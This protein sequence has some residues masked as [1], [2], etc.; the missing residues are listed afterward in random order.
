[1]QGN[2]KHKAH[3][4]K[5]GKHR[6]SK[7]IHVLKL[8][9]KVN[10]QKP[11][12]NKWV[13]GVACWEHP[14]FN[15]GKQECPSIRN[16]IGIIHFYSVKKSPKHKMVY[17]R[18]LIFCLFFQVLAAPVKAVSYN[19]KTSS[20]IDRPSVQVLGSYKNSWYVIGFDKPGTLNKPP[21][22]RFLKYEEGFPGAKVSAIY[23]SFGDKTLYLGAAILNKRISLFYAR[24]EKWA[25]KDFLLD[26]REGRR[27][28]PIV[29]Q[30][31]YDP[32]SLTQM[33]D[34]KVIFD[35]ADEHFAV[36]G[37][38]IATSS[39]GRKTAILLKCWYRADK[40]KVIL[41]DNQTGEVYASVFDFKVLKDYLQFDELAVNN[42]GRVL[43]S[44]H[45]RSDVINFAQDSKNKGQTRYYFF[46][47][48]KGG[49]ELKSLTLTSPAGKGQFFNNPQIA[50]LNDG[51]IVV[52][53]CIYP[54]D[55][56][57][58]VKAIEVDKYDV[59]L[60]LTA[61]KEIAPDAKFLEQAGQGVRKES[62]YADVD[63]IQVLPLE[64][65]NFMMFAEYAHTTLNADK[66]QPPLHERGY[67]LTWRFGN[68][69]DVKD[70]RFIAKKQ[71]SATAAYAFSARAYRQGNDV[72]LFHNDDWESDDD[73]ETNLFCTRFPAMGA[74]PDTRKVV[75]TSE[76]FYASMENLFPSPDGKVLFTEEKLVDYDNVSREVKLLEVTVK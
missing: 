57:R 32:D 52:A 23:P 28:I 17:T 19:I 45:T 36:S 69:L 63:I 3:K 73:N 67:L 74:D 13:L 14:F 20:V 8:T 51:G 46:S 21:E 24:C 10:S 39:N 48:D 34:P 44:A 60:N 61:K 16:A 37:I 58:V 66:N 27:E 5:D 71:V 70:S 12:G 15:S 41:T 11:N 68:S 31:D 26:P 40:Y 33:G 4:A 30:I 65:G 75:H 22:Y 50:M 47:I 76:G 49:A 35:E 64:A 53:Y 6:C 1:Y 18:L 72:Y 42:D 54:D 43:V 38:D 25:D 9:A 55:K 29:Y 7:R 59:E 56:S 62:G 2:N